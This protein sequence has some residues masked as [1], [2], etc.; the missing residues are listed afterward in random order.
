MT[1]DD[2]TET[3]AYITGVPIKRMSET[4]LARMLNIEQELQ[5]A[6]VDSI[7]AIQAVARALRRSRPTS[8]SCAD[9]LLYLSGANRRGQDPPGQ[10]AG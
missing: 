6:V 3:V 4:E 7:P 8:R 1:V 5:E 2:V 9:R 10:G